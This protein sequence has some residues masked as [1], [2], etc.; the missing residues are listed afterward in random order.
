MRVVGCSAFANNCRTFEGN[1][2]PTRAPRSST[3]LL[4][5]YETCERLGKFLGMEK[6]DGKKISVALFK[7]EREAHNAATAQCN[8]ETYG[9]Q[10][11]RSHYERPCGMSEWEDFCATVEVRIFGVLVRIPDAF[12]FNKDPHGYALKIDNETTE[13]KS[14]IESVGLEIDWGGYGILS[15]EI[16]GD[17]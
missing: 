7:L 17:A 11:F 2:K 13:G 4:K 14:L 6:P 1:A 8:G 9:G 3:Q 15:P 10:P 12:F 5:H 16:N